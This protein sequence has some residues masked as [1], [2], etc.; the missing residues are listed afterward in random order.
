[1]VFWALLLFSLYHWQANLFPY[2]TLLQI[3]LACLLLVFAVKSLRAM[4]GLRPFAIAFD[5]QGEWY[6]LG[7]EQDIQWHI[8]T[9]SRVTEWLLW[10]ELVSPVDP[11]QRHWVLIFK[12]QL[13]EQ[14]YRRLC[15]AILFQQSRE[16]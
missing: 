12:D 2:Q 13:D 7:N 8:T 6:Y 4:S 1:M 15:R 3:I 5:Q 10:I 16:H 9:K 11:T 14:N